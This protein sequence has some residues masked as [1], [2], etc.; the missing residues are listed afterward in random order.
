MAD[1]PLNLTD[2]DPKSWPGGPAVS[3]RIY[4]DRDTEIECHNTGD[5]DWCAR[6]ARDI[7]AYA[8]AMKTTYCGS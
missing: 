5:E 2:G 6:R 7:G 8:Y 4:S 1:E 3:C